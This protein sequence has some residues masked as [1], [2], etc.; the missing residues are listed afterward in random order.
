MAEADVSVW[1]TLALY[2]S[3]GF[4]FFLS[5][6]FLLQVVSLFLALMPERAPKLVISCSTVTEDILLLVCVLLAS[7]WLKG[8]KAQTFS[9]GVEAVRRFPDLT[10]QISREHEPGMSCYEVMRALK[11]CKAKHPGQD[12]GICQH[13]TSAA[14]WCIF[15]SICPREVA[16][17]EDCVGVK[18][19]RAVSHIPA[20]C[21]DREEL[22]SACLEGTQQAANDRKP[23]C[24]SK[25]L[26]ENQ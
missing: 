11:D 1:L 10:Q 6:D 23:P 8:A 18:N 24:K 2:F 13:L 5:R 20:R 25:K 21:A 16:A 9:R 22:L 12:N 26:Q 17:L 4:C 15:Q 19:L 14:G 7:S 3:V